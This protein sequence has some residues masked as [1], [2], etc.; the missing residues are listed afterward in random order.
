MT[1]TAVAADVQPPK[2][3]YVLALEEAVRALDHLVS[4]AMPD[5]DADHPDDHTLEPRVAALVV[6]LRPPA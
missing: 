4:T 2:M 1:R 3:L 5:I 6:S